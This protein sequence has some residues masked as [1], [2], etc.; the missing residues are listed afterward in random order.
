MTEIEPKISQKQKRPAPKPPEPIAVIKSTTAVITTQP[1][2]IATTKT[3]TT[4]AADIAETKTT[5]SEGAISKYFPED[6]REFIEQLFDSAITTTTTATTV[7]EPI[8]KALIGSGSPTLSSG[9]YETGLD[10]NDAKPALEVRVAEVAA[11]ASAIKLGEIAT[12]D[13]NKKVSALE[14][15]DDDDSLLASSSVM[16]MTKELGSIGLL[17]KKN[18]MPEQNGKQKDNKYKKN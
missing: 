14:A 18:V 10:W 13:N 1:K 12:D 4:V 9:D 6:H 15:D 16:L 7:N 5:T 8:A 17:T 3:T 11:A 2:T